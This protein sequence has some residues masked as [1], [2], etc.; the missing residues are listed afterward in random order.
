MTEIPFTI[1]ASASCTDGA[2]GQALKTQTRRCAVGSVDASGD[3]CC[4][5]GRR[6]E[7]RRK[8]YLAAG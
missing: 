7:Y 4:E 5:S 2:C 8:A 1:G 6:V 3:A